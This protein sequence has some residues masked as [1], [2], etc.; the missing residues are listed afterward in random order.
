MIEHLKHSASVGVI[1]VSMLAGYPTIAS[2]HSVEACINDV[3]D[4]CGNNDHDCI[5]SGSQAC[6]HH[7]HPGGRVPDPPDPVMSTDPGR[8][9]NQQIQNMTQ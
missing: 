7:S 8:K 3:Y 4:F 6:L 2:A 1:A 5:H 9:P